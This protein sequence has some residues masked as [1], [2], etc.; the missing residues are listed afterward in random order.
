M[1][2]GQLPTEMGGM[3]TSLACSGPRHCHPYPEETDQVAGYKSSS[4]ELLALSGVCPL[5]REPF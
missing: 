2:G 5:G 3:R 1:L 4:R